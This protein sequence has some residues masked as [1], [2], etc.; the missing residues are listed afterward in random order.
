VIRRIAP[1]RL[2]QQ[3]DEALVEFPLTVVFPTIEQSRLAARAEALYDAVYRAP[4]NAC[5]LR[6]AADGTAVQEVEHD[7]ASLI[8]PGVT[9]E[10]SR[11][12]IERL[13]RLLTD[14]RIPSMGNSLLGRAQEKLQWS[15]PFTCAKPVQQFTCAAPRYRAR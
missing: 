1:D 4:G 3:C 15:S 9:C 11:R 7:Q 14:D 13:T 5:H 10:R 2:V 6:R 12:L 8:H